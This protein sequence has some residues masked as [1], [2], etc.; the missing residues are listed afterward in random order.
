MAKE[1]IEA[2]CQKAKAALKQGQAEQARQLYLQALGVRSDLPDVHYGLAT[3]CFLLHDYVSAAHHFKE[4][5]R[6]D[7][8]HAGAFINLG[9]VYNRM[10]LLD[11]AILVL[12][13]GIQLDLNRGEG[14]YNLGLVYRRKGQLDLAIQAYREATRVNPRMSD[15][16]YNLANLYF[17]RQQYGLAITHY[18]SALELRPNWEKALNSLEQAEAADKAQKSGSPLAKQEAEQAERLAKKHDLE[19]TVDPMEHGAILNSLHNVTI[20]SENQGRNLLKILLSEIEPAI[21]ELS[22]VLL[23]PDHSVTEL[24]Q[25]VEKF[26]SG[27][28]NMQTVQQNLRRSVERVKTLSEQLLKH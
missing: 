3:V 25:C 26:E 8:L 1:S 7:P 5:T 11:D 24:D 18:K 19:R 22:N 17:E 16:H 14:Y 2:I 6:L 15:A 27:M 23:Q 12:R 21:K 20:E 13:R 28:S 10:D 9:A 4:V